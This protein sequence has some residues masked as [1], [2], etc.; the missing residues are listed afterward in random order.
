[1]TLS[2][3]AVPES[4]GRVDVEHRRLLDLSVVVVSYNRRD[5]LVRCLE[6]VEADAA[7]LDAEVI[8]VDNAS[9]D[10][11]ARMVA[12]TFPG[13]HLIANEQNVGFGKAN[14][15]AFAVARGRYLLVLNPDTTVPPGT[16][17]ALVG[18]ADAHPEAGLVGPRLEFEDGAFQHSAFRFPDWK[19]ALFGFFDVVPEN[20]EINGRYP[21]EQL[22]QPFLAEHLLGACLLLRREALEQV[23]SF[24][25]EYFMYFEE[26]D[27]CFRLRRAGWQNLYAPDV[28]VVH[29][30]GGSTSAVSETMSV[31]FHRSQATFYRR[32]RGLA[33]YVVLKAIVWPGTAYRLARSLRAYVR[34]RIGWP[35]LRERVVGY[36]RILW[37]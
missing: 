2:S 1:M 23:G 9:Q 3:T 10:G 24:A 17:A 34:G 22:A 26:T 11:S 15:Q 18:V 6:S 12:E 5:L 28:R 8:V 36:W 29:I 27:L 30:R 20:S 16:L 14:N 37:F 4:V 21:A 32:N 35:P 19:Q 25:P 31:A 13:V 33:G 7:A